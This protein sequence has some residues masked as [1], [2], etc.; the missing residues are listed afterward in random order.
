MITAKE[1][2]KA[3]A[4]LPKSELK[5]FRAWF[6]E[7]DSENWDSQIESDIDSGKLSK[8]GKRALEEHQKNK[9][10]II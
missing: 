1:L 7:Y 9:T 6:A 4:S 3:I 2:E 10:K 8:L 5:E